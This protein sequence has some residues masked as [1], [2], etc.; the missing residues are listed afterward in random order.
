MKEIL[1]ISTCPGLSSTDKCSKIKIYRDKKLAAEQ[2]RIYDWLNSLK[3]KRTEDEVKK[4]E[5]K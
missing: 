4:D 2:K 5:L 3:Y 1:P